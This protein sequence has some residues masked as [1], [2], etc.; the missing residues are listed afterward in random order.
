MRLP[1]CNGTTPSAPRLSPRP[2]WSWD[3]VKRRV[4][5]AL[6]SGAAEPAE[7]QLR[8]GVLLI[9]LALGWYPT[10]TA[11]QKAETDFPGFLT[12]FICTKIVNSL[13]IF[14]ANVS[15]FFGT[16]VATTELSQLPTPAQ[17][18]TELPMAHA[19]TQ[20]VTMLWRPHNLYTLHSRKQELSINQV[21]HLCRAAPGGPSLAEK[22]TLPPG[23]L[24]ASSRPTHSHHT[25]PDSPTILQVLLLL[26]YAFRCSGHHREVAA[27]HKL[28]AAG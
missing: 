14:C 6:R 25:L 22:L 13:I 27:T 8:A 24:L 17:S 9:S 26:L 12:F 1:R 19:H 20:C 15:S 28:R 10:P 2:A 7:P 18:T 16:P 5:T 11:T 4:R 23:Q 3:D 21:T